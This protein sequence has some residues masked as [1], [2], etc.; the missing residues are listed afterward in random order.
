MT[1]SKQC[2]CCRVA[3]QGGPSSQDV[4]NEKEGNSFCSNCFS[5][6]FGWM[7][8]QGREKRWRGHPEI[9]KRINDGSGMALHTWLTSFMVATVIKNMRTQPLEDLCPPSPHDKSVWQWKSV[10][11]WTNR[12][13]RSII[14][15]S[16]LVSAGCFLSSAVDRSVNSPTS[17][18]PAG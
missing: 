13:F 16:D 5:T 14:S 4:G 3:Q 6:W 8:R 9:W 1:G 10:Q 12:R 7:K 15:I 18:S 17:F 11:P 2:D